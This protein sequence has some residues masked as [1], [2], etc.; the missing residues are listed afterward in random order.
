LDCWRPAGASAARLPSTVTAT[1]SWPA[2]R[3]MPVPNS[4]RY[5]GAGALLGAN[6]EIVRM[7]AD[8]KVDA[9]VRIDTPFLKVDADRSI[10]LN[11]G[12]EETFRARDEC[13]IQAWC[14]LKDALF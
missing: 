10:E 12:R 11:A 4:E 1:S 8:V 3:R 6:A 14:V 9:I 5:T 13:R 7:N 2:P